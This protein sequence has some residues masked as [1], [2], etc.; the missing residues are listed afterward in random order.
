MGLT[1]SRAFQL[2]RGQVLLRGDIKNLLD[3]QYEIVGNYPMPGISYK[4]AINYKF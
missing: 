3:Q 4:F 2:C 1:L